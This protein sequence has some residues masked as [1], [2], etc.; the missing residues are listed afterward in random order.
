MVEVTGTRNWRYRQW[1]KLQ[2]QETATD[3]CGKCRY[4]KT[5]VFF[6][7]SHSSAE[8]LRPLTAFSTIRL[9]AFRSA[10][11][12]TASGRGR[13]SHCTMSSLHLRAGL[14]LGLLPLTVP[15]IMFFN[16]RLSSILQ[17]WPNRRSFRSLNVS[18]MV[19]SLDKDFLMES[20]VTLSLQLTFIIRR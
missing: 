10:A 14:P 5:E 11:M 6:F 13:P 1:W 16:S 3:L 8:P 17:I 2:V 15:S 12:W 7:Q 9:Q 4:W 19:C 18:M 20:F